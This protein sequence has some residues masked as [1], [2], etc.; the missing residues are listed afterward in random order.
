M[1]QRAISRINQYTRL[2][3]KDNLF[4]EK[5]VRELRYDDKRFESNAAAIRYY[6]HVGIAAEDRVKAA[7]SLDDQI[8]KASQ[9]EVVVDS[10]MPLK[11]SIDGLI[12]AM[13]RF[14]EKQTNHFV[15]QSRETDVLARRIEG[16]FAALSKYLTENVGAISERLKTIVKTNSDTLRGIVMLRSMIY[17]MLLGYS[18][19]VM[20]AIDVNRW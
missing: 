6:V 15:S 19:G 20:K 13:E 9:K 14:E 12:N 1:K 16:G 18:N 4:V 7:N 2:F 8:I 11:K 3:Q 5:K 10:L 17:V